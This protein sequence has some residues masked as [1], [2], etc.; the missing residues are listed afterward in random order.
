MLSFGVA[1]EES[2]SGRLLVAIVPQ[3]HFGFLDG[4]GLIKSSPFIGSRVKATAECIRCVG[5]FQVGVHHFRCRVDR[6]PIESEGRVGGI[7]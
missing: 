6:R 2:I 3:H 7:R 1:I 4:L 5:V